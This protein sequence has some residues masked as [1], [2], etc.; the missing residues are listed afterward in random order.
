MAQCHRDGHPGGGPGYGPPCGPPDNYPVCEEVWKYIAKELKHYFIDDHGECT[1]LAAQ[2][3]RLPLHDC[4]P[5][6]GCDGSIILTDECSRP[7]N[8][9]MLSICG[10][11][12]KMYKDYRVGAAD[13]INFAGSIA[14]KACPWGPFIPF[15]VGRHDNPTPAPEYQMPGA[16]SNASTLIAEFAA[17]GFSVTDLV[18]LVGAHSVGGDLWRKP[19]DTT[20]GVMD[21]PTYYT[22]VLVGNAPSILYSD[23]SL[24]LDPASTDDWQLYARDQ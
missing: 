11:L 10:V 4:F 17:R 7:E 24:A 15:Y 13:L 2:A 19:F 21:S 20:P 14:N 22:E 8:W 9:Q 3:V 1:Q 12:Y 16:Y 18:A 6:G 23:K 5:D